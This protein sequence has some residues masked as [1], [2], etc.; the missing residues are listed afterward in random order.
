[1][2]RVLLLHLQGN[3][4]LHSIRLTPNPASCRRRH[5]R[6]SKF[7]CSR[8]GS[9]P[10]HRV[11]LTLH[12]Y[13]KNL[14]WLPISKCIMYKVACMGSSSINALPPPP[15]QGGVRKHK[16]D[17]QCSLKMMAKLLVV[18]P[19]M[20]QITMDKT[21]RWHNIPEMILQAHDGDGKQI[22]SLA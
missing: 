5:H 22:S 7:C 4:M 13:C 10:G 1:M 18:V 8:Q 9:F 20:K 12:C 2:L 3:G 11:I 21:D 14:H 15:S 17:R 6:Y 19:V 16:G